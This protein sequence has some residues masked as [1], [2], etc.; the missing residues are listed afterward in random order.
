MKKEHWL[1]IERLILL[2][3]ILFGGTGYK[4]TAEKVA[5]LTTQVSTL[6]TFLE[7]A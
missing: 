1:Y 3:A 4:E 6:N 5:S 7:I 2:V